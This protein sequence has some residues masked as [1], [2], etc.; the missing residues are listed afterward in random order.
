VSSERPSPESSVCLGAKSP[1]VT[2]K[3]FHSCCAYSPPGFDGLGELSDSSQVAARWQIDPVPKRSGPG[4]FPFELSYLA[5]ASICTTGLV[6]VQD[7]LD[8]AGG[9]DEVT[10][11]SCSRCCASAHWTSPTL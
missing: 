7:E 4:W 3:E 6:A 11:T 5:Q 10:P 2:P 9:G 8:V 1:G